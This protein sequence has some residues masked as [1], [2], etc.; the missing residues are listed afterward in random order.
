[1]FLLIWVRCRPRTDAGELGVAE[2]SVGIRGKGGR[3]VGGVGCCGG[4]EGIGIAFGNV[5]IGGGFGGGDFAG[6]VVGEAG[7][8]VLAGGVVEDAFAVDVGEGNTG[9]DLEGLPGEDAFLDHFR[10]DVGVGGGF[11]GFLGDLAGD[12]VLAVAVRYVADEG[13]R[14]D[15]GAVDADGADG[16]VEDAV[17]GP[18]G[19]GFFFSFG[20]AEVDLGAEHLVDADVAVVGE[21]LLGADEAE[22][23]FEVGGDEVLAAFAAGEGEVGDTG[24]EAAGVEGQHA[25]VLVVGVGDDVEDG[26]AGVET[27]KELGEAE[28]VAVDGELVTVGGRDALAAEVGGVGEG[29]LRGGCEGERQEKSD[30]LHGI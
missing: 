12:L 3:D 23:V 20:E 10:E 8:D 14:D 11:E 4:E 26:G 22:R 18:L 13:G 2:G 1:M 7:G 19:E 16:V 24:A 27:A 30:E 5:Y 17:V 15:E 28:G 25:A 29:G 21:E 9:V 6:N